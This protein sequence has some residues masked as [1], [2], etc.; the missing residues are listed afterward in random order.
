M[1]T[2]KKIAQVV[3]AINV[4]STDLQVVIE[5]LIYDSRKISRPKQA[6]FFA[7]KGRRDG[8]QF[9]RE[10][11][12]KGVRNFMVHAD[13]D[14]T[15]LVKCNV[16]F[17]E[18]TLTALQRLAAFH[19]NRF[20]YPV[21]G[22][23]GSNG[24]T[25]V[26]EWLYQLLHADYHMVRSPKSYNSQ[27]GVALSL[28]Q[29]NDQHNLAI[30]E[31]G[32]SKPG[33]MAALEE[34][35]RPTL[36]VLTNIGHAHDEGFVSQEQKLGEKLILF[37]RAKTLVFSPQYI[38]PN[39]AAYLL[40]EKQFA[41]NNS[42]TADLE[43]LTKVRKAQGTMLKARYKG[44]EQHVF[45]P[46]TDA[47]SLENAV[48]CWA[49][50]LVL[51]FSTESIADKFQR[52]Q[53]V[54]M[55]LALKQGINNCSIL[56]DS[57]SNDL[58]SLKIAL[59]FLKQQQQHRQQV[60]ILSDIPTEEAFQESIYRELADLLN[61]QNIRLIGV[62]TVI[63]SYKHFFSAKSLFFPSTDI[64]LQQLHQLGLR[65]A[66]ILIKGARVFSFER[67]SKALVIQHHETT[68]EINLNAL[69]HNLNNYKRVLAP[70]TK[71]MVMV[72]AFSY[73]SGSFEI[74]NL[75]QFNQVDYL[76]VAYADE[77]VTLRRAGITLPIVI[78]SPG[79]QDVDQI[80]EHRLEPE[81][82]SF[83]ELR[84]F[85][86]RL[87]ESGQEG[88]PIHVKVD[89]G[90]HRLGFDPDDLPK[91][92]EELKHDHY[93]LVS[94]VFSHLVASGDPQ[95]D[96][97]TR[98]QIQRFKVFTSTMEKGLGYTFIRHIANTSAIMRFPEAQLDMVRL[99]IGLYGISSNAEDALSLIPIAQLKTGITQ[100]KS[101]KAGETIGY[102]RHGRLKGEGTI[103]TVK[104]GYADGYSRR[105]GNGVGK[106]MI[107]GHL[108][109]TV[110]DICMDMCMLD[111][112]G[113]PA[114][115]GDEV[116]VMGEE[117]SAESLAKSIDTIP[118]ELLTGISQRVRRIY[119]YE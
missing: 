59:D 46:F 111:I 73:G 48:C 37:K 99:G 18:D 23:T 55:R 2:I 98:E 88:Y 47:A 30:V 117:L 109:P 8:H 102:N 60:V 91:L 112:S 69:E 103:A 68:L 89:T 71:L 114:Q 80:I 50:L 21:I 27:L 11:Y 16:L 31:A 53:P 115:E 76:T 38:V 67:V 106:M 108:V 79:L 93:V 97:F 12:I 84:Y 82:Y 54:S 17:V 34:M 7:L 100:I 119:F 72:K 104:I 118:Y 35:I 43:I 66:S 19:R 45:V 57:Y 74:A 86:E 10:A 61:E 29:M 13:F 3:Q 39:L 83:T 65:D 52:L 6:L 58:S 42:G 36:G 14:A 63:S 87:K 15:A 81:I 33:E 64:L 24:K 85:K 1:Y 90:M 113:I 107:N 32:I 70:N 96:D 110:G 20:A 44:K 4:K 9:V 94:S 5:D 92:L 78:M 75:L 28:W 25:I 56:D 95:H 105:F 51:G 41:W 22:I 26:K 49:V 116:L 62:G 40:P 101:I 77:G